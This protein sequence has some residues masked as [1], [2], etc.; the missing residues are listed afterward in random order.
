MNLGQV[1]CELIKGKSYVEI[2][3]TLGISEKSVDNALR[4]MREKVKK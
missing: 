3:N 1:F 2:A 4:R